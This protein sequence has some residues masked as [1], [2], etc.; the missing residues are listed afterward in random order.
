MQQCKRQAVNVFSQI[1]YGAVAAGLF[2]REIE[3]KAV[4]ALNG[5]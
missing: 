2:P 1:V 5:A 4:A 3:E